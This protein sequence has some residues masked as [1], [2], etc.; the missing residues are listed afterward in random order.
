[1]FGSEVLMT[2]KRRYRST[3]EKMGVKIPEQMKDVTGIYPSKTSRRG[4][5]QAGR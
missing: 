5:F 2:F 1:M 3:R 4:Q